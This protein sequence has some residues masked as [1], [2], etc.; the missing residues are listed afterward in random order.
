M[1]SSSTLNC[2]ECPIF[3]SIPALCVGRPL[4]RYICAM[5]E[6]GIKV[7]I[8]S[9]DTDKKTRMLGSMLGS[10]TRGS[11]ERIRSACHHGSFEVLH[12]EKKIDFQSSRK[13]YTVRP[14]KNHK[15]RFRPPCIGWRIYNISPFRPPPNVSGASFSTSPL[16]PLICYYHFF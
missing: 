2:Q 1:P 6:A 10:H 8:F 15:N 5:S 4:S 12:E 13:V 9:A 3:V 14:R 16:R 11:N 7:Q